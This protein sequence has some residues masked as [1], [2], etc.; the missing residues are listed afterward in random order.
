[1]HY[2]RSRVSLFFE[3]LLT[4][5]VAI[6]LSSTL[7]TPDFNQSTLDDVGPVGGSSGDKFLTELNEIQDRQCNAG[8]KGTPE[9]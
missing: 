6:R 8:Q 2:L 3:T 4:T 5:R 9:R 7:A 1:V